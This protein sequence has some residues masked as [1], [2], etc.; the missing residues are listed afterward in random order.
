MASRDELDSKVYEIDFIM[1]P[2]GLF[3]WSELI[4]GLVYPYVIGH[5]KKLECM[6]K[7]KK[8]IARGNKEVQTEKSCKMNQVLVHQV[9]Q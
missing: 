7:A 4:L 1:T 2:F 5:M 8:G 9:S 3:F 6:L